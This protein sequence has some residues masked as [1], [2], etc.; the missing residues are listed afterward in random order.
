[1]LLGALAL[2]T[3]GLL[4][5]C[6]GSGTG[7]R[8][9][10]NIGN[11]QAA[12]PGSVDYPIFYV[13]RN[14]PAASDDL[15]LLR[16][17]ASGNTWTP[18]GA[19]LYM[20]AS[21]S[22]GATES[23]ISAR[24][25]GPHDVKDVDTSPDGK[26][27]VFALR[28]PLKAGQNAKAQPAWHI[29]EY[30][31]A[32]DTLA[33]MIDPAVDLDPQENDVSPHYLPDG[34][35]VFS[36]TR[37]RQSKAVLLDEGKPQFDA[38]DE[39]RTEPAFNLHVISVDRSQIT[40]ISFNQ[41][42][43]RDATVLQSGRILYSRWDNAPGHDAM[44]LYSA[45]PDGTDLQ[46][47]YGANSHF[48][49]V[50][51]AGPNGPVEIVR[52]KE[53]QDGHILALLRPYSDGTGPTS[54][55]DS[56]GELV[57]I[58]GQHY[59]ENT[60]LLGSSTPSGPAQIPATTLQ[61][62]TTPGHSPGGRFSSAYPLWDG[63]GRLLVT[64]TQCRVIDPVTGALDF[65][66]DALLA[67]PL[68]QNG[69]P[70][71]SVW[72]YNPAQGQFLPVME[73]IEGTMVTD[74][75]A[76]MP[77]S[78]IPNIILPLTPP[79]DLLS[80]SLGVIDIRSVYDFEG[81]DVAPAGITAVADGKTAASQ[82]PARFVRLVKAV[83]LPDTTVKN[84]SQ[85]AFGPNGNFMRE[86]LGY[87]PVEPDGSV[88]ARVPADVAFQVQVLDANGRQIYPQ[89][90]TWLQVG[91]G[92]TLQCNGCHTPAASQTVAT[93]Q[94][95]L[96]H[97]RK[98]S[99]AS[100]YPPFPAGVPYPNSVATTTVIASDG[101]ATTPSVTPAATGDTMAES[102]SNATCAAASTCSALLGP[103]VVYTDVWTAPGLTT[104][105]SIS[106]TYADLQAS[107]LAPVSTTCTLSPTAW[108]AVCRTIINYPQ[109]IQPIWDAPRKNAA[110]NDATCTATCHN[111]KNTGG[112]A[113]HLDLTSAASN[114]VPQQAISYVDLLTQ[115]T[116]TNADGTVTP[117][118]GPFFDAGNANGPNSKTSFALLGNGGDT[119]HAGA[120]TPA[121]LRLISE[122]LDI[123]AEYFNNPFDP[124]VPV[125]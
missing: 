86:I 90:G 80:A 108:T 58:D 101:T 118:A 93:T 50:D 55:I 60:Q 79:A 20:R 43:D 117:I 31:I 1:V 102:R 8:G 107:E 92:E 36:S 124:A 98:G 115:Q 13:K 27:V 113:A 7:S 44:S 88:V 104:N 12:D 71:Y 29:Y 81:K 21:A 111:P 64:W 91:A 4:G 14:V 35:I 77:R 25:A 125:N 45:N 119:I 61:I 33:P 105:P 54:T 110:G 96:S 62:Y 49:G 84:L 17:F 51:A 94:S 72:I 5:A 63:T 65:C 106:Y 100:V 121:E 28:G 19:D 99:F 10:I 46:L 114:A 75:A 85:A 123:G 26:K 41:S 97:G 74:V 9:S 23:N 18:D 6:S 95:A 76:A 83:S 103:N 112:A 87:L 56:G 109:H 52:P 69:P 2:G 57:L 47:Y 53:T 15:R 39:A 73:P 67:N 122:W 70:L 120:L 37:Q 116:Q 42:H 34:R 22:P 24:L 59:V 38:Q 16:A 78:P 32:S 68:V 66:T 11:S 48:T 89:Q 30:T 40:Q 3:L 82:R